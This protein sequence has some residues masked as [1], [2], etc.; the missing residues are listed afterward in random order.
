MVSRK[1]NG[2]SR[3]VPSEKRGRNPVY[4]SNH[5]IRQEFHLKIKHVLGG[6]WFLSLLA[7]FQVFSIPATA[8][9]SGG[10]AITLHEEEI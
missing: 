1:N 2:K 8:G 5:N 7:A 9:L 4:T 3:T 6:I 10:A